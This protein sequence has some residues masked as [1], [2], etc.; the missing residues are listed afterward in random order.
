VASFLQ[1]HGADPNIQDKVCIATCG[2]AVKIEMG[3]LYDFHC[4]AIDIGVVSLG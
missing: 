3:T 1:Q 2:L 4:V